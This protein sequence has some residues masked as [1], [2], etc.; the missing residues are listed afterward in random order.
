MSSEQ[1][2]ALEFIRRSEMVL[3]KD[4]DHSM[5][6]VVCDLR[7]DNLI[8]LDYKNNEPHSIILNDNGRRALQAAEMG[9]V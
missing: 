3:W 6:Y 2:K 1:L 4:I 8:Y 7:L 5:R 9:D